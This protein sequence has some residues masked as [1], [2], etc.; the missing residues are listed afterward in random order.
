MNNKPVDFCKTRLIEGLISK[1]ERQV[2]RFIVRRSGAQVLKRATL[3][4][5]YQETVAAAIA[6]AGT[7]VFHDDRGFLAW[8]STIA[9]RVIARSVGDLRHEVRTTRIKGAE[10]TGVG[11]TESDLGHAGRTPLS[12][13]ARRERRVALRGAIDRLPDQHR[14]VVMLY[15]LEERSLSEVA[16]LMG[17]TK[18]ATCRLLARA[19]AKLR[20]LLEDDGHVE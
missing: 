15:K 20:T 18:G 3:E 2:R 10:S 19:V 12:S 13:A 6:S 7:F 14:R 4:D 1:H 11:I 5:L 17:R 16:A 9:R 8:I